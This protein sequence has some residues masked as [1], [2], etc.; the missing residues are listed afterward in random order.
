MNYLFRTFGSAAIFCLLASG[1]AAQADDICGEFGIVPSLEV[2]QKGTSSSAAGAPRVSA[3]LIFGKIAVRAHQEVANFP[4][5]SIIYVSESR[6]PTRLAVGKSGN[7]CFKRN[8]TGGG[9]LTVDIDGVEM[10]RRVL[11]TSGIPH[12]R[13]DFDIV[14]GQPEKAGSPAVISSKFYY[15]PNEKT[16]E[17]YKQA[18]SAEAAKETDKSA[19]LLKQIVA[20]DPLD[21]RAW[22]MLGAYHLERKSFADS[23]AALRKSIELKQEYPA[24]WVTVGRLRIDQKQYAAAIEILKH[25]IE[26]DPKSARAYQYLGEAYLQSKQ[27]SLG[28]EALNRSIELDPKGMAD[29]HLLIARLYDLAGAKHLA[30]REFKLYLDKVPNYPERKKLEKFIK[31]NPDGPVKQ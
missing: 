17:L 28:V 6:T 27:G 20:A 31:D 19:G 7:Y 25:A 9:T 18:A 3:P 13:E 24:P 23:E 4:S 29:S 15:P 22:A 30:A 12:Q 10:A 26:L 21:F 14:L 1:A 11:P 8:E 5:I 2:L 16:V